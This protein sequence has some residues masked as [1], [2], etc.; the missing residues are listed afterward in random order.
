MNHR[1]TTQTIAAAIIAAC[2]ALPLAA[3]AASH[4]GAAPMD[5]KATDSAVFS[6]RAK[7]KAWA[8]E[9]AQIEKAL[10]STTDRNGYA[11]ALSDMGYMVTAIN[12][13]RKDYLEYEVVKGANSYE[14]Q[15]SFDKDMA[16]AKKVDVTTNMWRADTTK[17]A[18][19]G[20]QVAAATQVDAANARYSDRAR[21]QGWSGEKEQLEKALAAGQT[22]AQYEAM[23]KK[24]GYQVTSVNDAEKDYLEYEVV[25]GDN[26][27]EVQIDLDN[28]VGKKVDVTTN[29]WETA[30]TEK[31]LASAKR[32]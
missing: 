19:R 20:D 24:M 18:L 32:K 9:K 26:S 23:L 22:R 8:T 11:K 1:N 29:L 17:A 28:K 30:A 14:V 4:S 27:Y 7:S 5:K 10:Q 21:M 12:A 31:A 6:D 16:K 13:D 3:T 2:A 15:V 25:K